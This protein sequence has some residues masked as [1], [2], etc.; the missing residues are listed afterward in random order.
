MAGYW[1]FLD[2]ALAVI[3]V[4]IVWRLQLSTQK[5]LLLTLLLS[6]GVLC[7][8][9]LLLQSCHIKADWSLVQ[10][11]GV[12]AAVKTSKVPITV[13]AKTDITC[14]SSNTWCDI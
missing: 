11:A 8:I 3:P 7:V 9:D 10:S 1:A 14:M 2:F 12:C 6:M 5:K 13:K 4:D